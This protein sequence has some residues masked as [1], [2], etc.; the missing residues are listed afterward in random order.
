[1]AASWLKMVLIHRPYLRVAVGPCVGDVTAALATQFG[2]C[3]AVVEQENLHS[4]WYETSCHG[5]YPS[6]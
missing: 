5:G 2:S 1:M 6:I 4:W 3:F